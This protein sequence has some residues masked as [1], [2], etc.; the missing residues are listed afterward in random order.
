MHQF[1]ADLILTD[2]AGD[3]VCVVEVKRRASAAAGEQVE[4]LMDRFGAPYG[5]LLTPDALDVYAA[6]EADPERNDA[7]PL[8]A[9]LREAAGVPSG[10][11]PEVALSML[12]RLF[13]EDLI[14][15]RAP[16]GGP[17]LAELRTAADGGWVAKEFFAGRPAGVAA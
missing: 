14:A 15:G 4:F 13:F 6:G 8:L 7:R 3:P 1:H 5:A 2:D 16:A 9:P 10:D 12:A 17:R 11:L